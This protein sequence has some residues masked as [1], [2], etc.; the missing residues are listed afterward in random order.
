[1]GTTIPRAAWWLLLGAAAT[2]LVL[3]VLSL[4]PGGDAPAEVHGRA[5]V[6]D[7]GSGSGTTGDGHG[8]EDRP[9]RDETPPR[10]G[11][12]SADLEQVPASRAA[13]NATP[14]ALEVP[15]LGLAVAV[16][17]TGATASGAMQLPADPA[18][19]GWYRYGPAPG[20]SGSVVLAG[21]VD[22]RRF[23]VGPLARLS[24]VEAG[25]RVLVDLSSGTRRAYRVD[26][27]ERFDRRA[28]PGEV[29][30]RTGAERLRIVTCTGPYN[31]AAGGYQQ[32]LVV[33]AL[34]DATEPAG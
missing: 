4:R 17:P 10:T 26:S 5:A 27:I 21:H 30:A 34:P 9:G 6:A 29:F 24:G 25:D 8:G 13:S 14:V 7:T 32:N 20:R 33:T 3:G 11:R 16:R 18:I 12:S 28:L 31:A 2:G 23:G 19:V 15:G 22:S 1:M